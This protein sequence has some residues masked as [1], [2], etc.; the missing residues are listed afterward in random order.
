VSLSE[1]DLEEITALDKGRRYL[2]GEFL[3]LR[4]QP[5]Y[6]KKSLGRIK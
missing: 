3:R 1:E 2:A 6:T 4:R 5:V